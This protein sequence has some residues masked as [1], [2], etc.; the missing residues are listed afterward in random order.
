MMDNIFQQHFSVNQWTKVT[1]WG[2]VLGIA[3]VLIISSFL[4]SIGIEHSQFYLGVGMGAGVGFVQWMYLKKITQVSLNWVW[5][6]II[7]MGI[8]FVVLDFISSEV[9][10]HKL[11]ISITFGALTVGFLQYLILR[12]YS[13]KANL[14]ILGSFIG[15]ALGVLTV[16]IINYTNNLKSVIPSN[17]VLAALNLLLMFAGGIILGIITGI[18]IKIILN[19]K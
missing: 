13:S 18:T 12:K 7:G 9:I 2:W 8:P 1:F 19:D 6:S 4:G 11:P 17:L 10:A 14:W 15:W 3:L 5:F 16:F